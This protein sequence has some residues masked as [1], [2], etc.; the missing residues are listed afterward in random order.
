[1]PL[2]IWALTHSQAVRYLGRRGNRDM[3]WKQFCLFRRHRATP[4][5][6]SQ[7][8]QR[9]AVTETIMVECRKPGCGGTLTPKGSSNVAVCPECRLLNCLKCDAVHGGKSCKEYQKSIGA[10]VSP[11]PTASSRGGPDIADR[12]EHFPSSVNFCS[13][14]KDIAEENSGTYYG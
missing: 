9:S 6:R 10:D 13:D 8:Q 2:D 11:A 5:D 1:M 12:K 7:Q 3:A 4:A 14:P